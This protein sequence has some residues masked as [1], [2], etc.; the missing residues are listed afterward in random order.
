MIAIVLDVN[1]LCMI[2]LD[3]IV[4]IQRILFARSRPL[5]FP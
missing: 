2:V 3:V 4:F 1:P 5:S